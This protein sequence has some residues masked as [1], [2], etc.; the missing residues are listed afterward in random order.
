MIHFTIGLVIGGLC[1]VLLMSC[2]A[3]A[4]RGNE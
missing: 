4:G 1:G 3:M 2:L